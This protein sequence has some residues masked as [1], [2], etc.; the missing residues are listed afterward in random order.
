MLSEPSRGIREV[1]GGVVH[2]YFYRVGRVDPST[3]PPSTLLSV[4]LACSL[5]PF[6]FSLRELFLLPSNFIVIIK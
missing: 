3:E 2:T 5:P 4:I 1:S 6:P